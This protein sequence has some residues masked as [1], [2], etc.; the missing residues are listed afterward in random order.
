LQVTQDWFPA[1][2]QVKQLESHTPQV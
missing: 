1:A 2:L